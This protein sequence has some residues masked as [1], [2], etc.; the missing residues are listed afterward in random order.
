MSEIAVPSNVSRFWTTIVAGDALAAKKVGDSL[1]SVPLVA[2]P[3]FEFPEDAPSSRASATTGA[4]D[5][6]SAAAAGELLV[7]SPQTVEP[8]T[9]GTTLSAWNNG[10]KVE[11]VVINKSVICGART[12]TEGG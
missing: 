4:A 8:N 12:V 6:A 11:V 9:P 1:T 5:I 3:T 7:L 10:T 2:V